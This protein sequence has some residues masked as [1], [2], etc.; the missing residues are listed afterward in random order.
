[1][2]EFL[3]R[4]LIA[5]LPL[6][7]GLSFPAAAG[8]H[9]TPLGQALVTLEADGSYRVIVTFDVAACVMHADQPGHLGDE[10][11]RE[12]QEMPADKLAERI[13]EARQVFQRRFIVRCDGVAAAPDEVYFPTADMLRE[14]DVADGQRAPRSVHIHGRTSPDTRSISLTFPPD[15]GQMLL[16]VVRSD[17]SVLH[18]TTGEGAESAPIAWVGAAESSLGRRVD[19][20]WLYLRL[21]FEH[22]LPKGLDHILF[23][24]GLYLLSPHWKPLLAQ[25]TMFTLAH[26]VTLALSSLEIVSLPASVVEPMIAL[27]IAVVAL[28][29]IVTARLHRWRL[30]IVFGFGLLHGL[31]F[32]GVLGELGLPRHE[33][34]TAL[35][36]FNVGVELG[37]VSVL[38]L[39]ALAV[40][41][42]RGKSWYRSAI[43]QPVSAV[44]A[45]VG[46]YWTI[47]RL[48]WLG[49]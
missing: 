4:P 14:G 2:S 13:A 25:V 36:T 35:V 22:I 9:P 34:V 26:S 48:G 17:D 45:L 12:L 21:G 42:F 20:A 29:N 28:E 47:E 41:W 46:L 24:L 40:G 49:A 8:A 38:L 31:G 30:P 5:L 27:S 1:M 43:V 11:A 19:V 33:F 37:Q 15:C 7:A 10:L 16:T 6:L 39:A 44:I 3:R 23:V 32:A 18:L